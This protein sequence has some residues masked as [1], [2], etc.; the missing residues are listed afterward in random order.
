MSIKLDTVKAADP[1][2][3]LGQVVACRF[4][5]LDTSDWASVFVIDTRDAASGVPMFLVERADCAG[6][7]GLARI[8]CGTLVCVATADA[9]QAG[10]GREKAKRVLGFGEAARMGKS[11]LAA[12]R[13]VAWNKTTGWVSACMGRVDN[14][15]V[16]YL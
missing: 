5:E 10:V 16:A 12:G 14:G 11:A 9:N 15:R 4:G 1:K 2:S 13:P 6:S 8:E 7:F 3:L